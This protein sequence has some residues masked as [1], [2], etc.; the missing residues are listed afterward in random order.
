MQG[1]MTNLKRR[2]RWL[3]YEAGSRN[4]PAFNLPKNEFTSEHRRM[5]V[6]IYQAVHQRRF[7]QLFPE[8]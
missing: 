7:R 5:M 8:T 1:I 2:V 3:V 6:P 4:L